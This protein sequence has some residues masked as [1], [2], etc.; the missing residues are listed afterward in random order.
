MTDAAI[1]QL[2]QLLQV[3]SELLQAQNEANKLKDQELSLK[4]QE[5][6]LEQ[7]KLAQEQAKV[8]LE[9]QNRDLQRRAINRA[10]TRLNEV[11]QRY[12]GLAERVEIL[13]SYAQKNLLR[14]DA[15]KDILV[16]LSERFE[17]VERAVLLA[18][19]D[20][21]DSPHI[22]KEAEETIGKLDY[23]LARA[24]KQ[25]QLSSKYKGLNKLKEKEAEGDESILVLNKI[26][27]LEQEITELEEWL[28]VNR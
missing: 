23:S 25:R 13:I 7:Q 6:A 2:H 24:S 16:Q 9:K 22:M 21:L 12:V 20:K 28:N 18:L 17:T 4:A 19:V 15:Y 5:L 11:L 8:E 27:K 10:E 3:N 26:E 1:D 14:D